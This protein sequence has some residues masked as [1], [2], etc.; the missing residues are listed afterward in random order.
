MENRLEHFCKPIIKLLQR[1][2]IDEGMVK[3]AGID[4][5]KQLRG[6]LIL[7]FGKHER[8]PDLNDIL[9]LCHSYNL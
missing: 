7:P 2:D 9:V 6:E 3:P 5:C 8:I 1:T 4:V